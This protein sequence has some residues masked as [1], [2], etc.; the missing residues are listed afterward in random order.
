VVTGTLDEHGRATYVVGELRPED[1]HTGTETGAVYPPGLTR[2]ELDPL[3]ARRG[4]LLANLFGGKG[5]DPRNL[6]WLYERV[7]LSSF[8]TRFENPIR[9][10]LQRGEDVRFSIEPN[11]RVGEAAPYEVEVWASSAGGT[12]QIVPVQR[13]PT[14]GLS[15]IP[16]PHVPTPRNL[17]IPVPAHPPSPSP[18]RRTR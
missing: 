13:I 7:N 11:Y 4:H 18:K 8:K 15:D 14:P 9:A 17:D 3:R 1:L 5:S 10:A 6:A 12:K 16:V 2:G